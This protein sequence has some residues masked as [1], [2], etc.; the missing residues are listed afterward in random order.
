MIQ[1]TGFVPR[2]VGSLACIAGAVTLA[3]AVLASQPVAAAGNPKFEGFLSAAPPTAFTSSPASYDVS[4]GPVTVNFDV[5]TKNLTDST[6]TVSLTVSADHILTAGG[7]NVST[8]QPG[9]AGIA[10]AGPAGTTQALMPGSHTVSESWEAN[11][12]QTLSF[13]YTFST[14]GYFQLDVWAP[15]KNGDNGRARATLASGFIRI[16]GCDI[17][18]QQPPSDPGSGVQGIVSTPSTGS[19]GIGLL[20][21]AGLVLAG[22]GSVAAGVRRRTR[23]AR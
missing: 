4:G 6:H 10:F 2:R 3:V 16:L 17:A 11:T 18:P 5:L 12:S 19:G 13:T 20:G 1:E 14:C 8:G 7:Q 21:G 15:W 22:I 9:Q 23:A